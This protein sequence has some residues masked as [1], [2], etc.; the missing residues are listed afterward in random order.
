MLKIKFICQNCKKEI[1]VQEDIYEKTYKNRK[2]CLSCKSADDFEQ[3]DETAQ[4]GRARDYIVH[5]EG[6]LINEIV[7]ARKAGNQNLLN[8]LEKKNKEVKQIH[9]QMDNY[10]TRK[11]IVCKYMQ[12]TNEIHEIVKAHQI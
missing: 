4:Y 11:H 7:K 12:M 1:E 6:T 3:L 10:E 9:M 8:K 2:N 5:V